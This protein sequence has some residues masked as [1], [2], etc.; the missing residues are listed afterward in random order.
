[1]KD[2]FGLWAVVLLV[3]GVFISLLL[4]GRALWP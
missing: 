4:S 1:M 2:Y 3:E